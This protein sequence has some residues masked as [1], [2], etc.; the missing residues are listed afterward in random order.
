MPDHSR[1]ALQ[2]QFPQLQLTDKDVVATFAG[3]RPVIAGKEGGARRRRKGASMS[4]GAV[5]ASSPSPAAS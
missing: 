1:N 3:V 5:P 2:A 4:C